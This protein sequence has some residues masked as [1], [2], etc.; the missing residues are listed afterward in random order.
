MEFGYPKYNYTFQYECKFR[1]DDPNVWDIGGELVLI[2]P[3][4]SKAEENRGERREER[5]GERRE[6]RR[7]ER[8]GELEKR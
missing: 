6:E 1:L 2:R 7:G 5:R 4:E 3:R 8:R